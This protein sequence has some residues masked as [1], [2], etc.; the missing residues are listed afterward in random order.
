MSSWEMC[1]KVSK[2]W[3]RVFGLFT[4]L[5]IVSSGL[6][7]VDGSWEFFRIHRLPRFVGI[8]RAV[9]SLG[10]LDTLTP[11]P[12]FWAHAFHYAVTMP[13]VLACL[14]VYGRFAPIHPDAY[15]MYS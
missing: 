11:W 8:A 10:I 13:A 1:E 2:R 6:R 15:G 4:I 7:I 9:G 12:G 3:F 14:W 5:M